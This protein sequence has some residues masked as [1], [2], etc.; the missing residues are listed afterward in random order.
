MIR[1]LKVLGLALVAM[2]ALGVVGASGAMAA[3]GTVKIG[4]TG[5]GNLDGI[6]INNN[7]FTVGGGRTV[8]CETVTFTA[9]M[10]AASSTVEKIIP[11][12]EK[13]TS[14][15]AGVKVPATVTPNGCTYTVHLGETTGVEDQYSGTADVVCPEGKLI[16]VHVYK[17][18]TLP[19][20][21]KPEN[22]LCG[23]TI[24]SQAGL[25]SGTVTNITTSTPKDLE[26]NL[27]LVKINYTRTLGTIPNCGAAAAQAT[28]SGKLTITGS[29]TPGVA[30]DIILSHP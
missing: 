24:G 21:H 19:A 17:E 4:A 25:G 9:S 10:A 3:N 22:Q 1:N 15:L 8:V 30:T 27:N 26:I 13:C 29:T 12:Y 5:D 14:T 16:E 28:L 2:L 11:K 20:N 18:G 6:Q 23:Y 7:V